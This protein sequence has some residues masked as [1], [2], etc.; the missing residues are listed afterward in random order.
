MVKACMVCHTH[1][2][3]EWYLTASQFL[4]KLVRF[5][6]DLLENFGEEGDPQSGAHAEETAPFMLDGQWIALEDYLR[7]RPAAEE[8]VKRA[9]RSG[10]LQVGPWYILPDEVLVSAE[11]HVRNALMGQRMADRYGGG[12]RVG[13]LPDSFGHP[14]QM[15]QILRGLGF[16]I[17]LFWRGTGHHMS[18]TE[19]IW[20][21]PYE[22][23]E[24]L[25]VHLA[26]GYGNS[27]CLSADMEQ[28]APRLIAM[29]GDL[30]KKSSTDLPLLMNGSDHIV[31]QRDVA[32]VLRA[33]QQLHPEYEIELTT[34][35][36]Y[37]AQL[38]PRLRELARYAGEV[39]YGDRAM[40]LGG[41]LST[42]QALKQQ[43][44]HV[45]RTM[46]R[47]L[48][49]LK[50]CEG[51]MGLGSSFADYGDLLWRRILENHPH[52]S[53]CGCGIDALHAEMQT[54]FAATRELQDT[55]LADAARELF[56]AHRAE[57]PGE[58]LTLLRFEPTQDG[59]PAYVETEVLL[60]GRM[61]SRVNFARSIIDIYDAE[62]P[63]PP[64][65]LRALDSQGREV[66]VTLLEC[67]A[68]DAMHLQDT[69]A[70][71]VYRAYRCRVAMLLPPSPLGLTAVTLRREDSAAPA[72]PRA[73][74]AGERA[75]ENVFYRVSF[76]AER[77]AFAV[78][79]K[80]TGTT[81]AGFARLI[82]RAD[83][84]DEY[85]YSWPT[86]DGEFSL[87]TAGLEV[88]TE[89]IGGFSR[90]LIVSGKLALP[91]SLTADRQRR[92]EERVDC[93]VKLTL[94]LH[95]GIDRIDVSID[96]ENCAEDHRLQVEFPAGVCA[97]TSVASSAFWVSERPVAL[98]VP[99]EWME[100][101][102]PSS[103]THGFV[104]VSD[105]NKG[106]SLACDG[107][108]EYE[109]PRE[110][111]QN[112][113]RVTLLRCVGWLSRP[114]LHTRKGNGGWQIATPG[115]Q[116]PG[117]FSA[118][119]SVRYHAGDWRQAGA[120]GF[121]DRFLHP[122]RLFPCFP[123]HGVRPPRN[124][125]AFLS[126]LPADVRLSACKPAQDERGWVVRVYNL[127]Q[128][129]RAV[130]LPLPA[131]IGGVLRCDLAERE[132]VPVSCAVSDSDPELRF[133]IAPGEVVSLR[134]MPSR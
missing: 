84:G 39:R 126:A 48:E 83:A 127:A 88:R 117:L 93:P 3:R 125:L 64:V 5:V 68:N 44:A 69:T 119:L 74:G 57:R 86:H 10:R 35:E 34:L 55:L 91:R 41:T 103:P 52:D 17:A 106:I 123:E 109:A 105:G 36:D 82:D 4:P 67:E 15:P 7:V 124:P 80:R 73:E 77:A 76:D 49:P 75:I 118:R 6:D 71:E 28:T 19:F 14:E 59:L 114:D 54:R 18:K 132:L 24:V 9:L 128:E 90:R 1:W 104:S 101:P 56:E 72:P 85:T 131:G 16:D 58:G 30:L 108:T 100:Y 134:L 40:L 53:I 129:H 26:H 45:Q 37:L 113:V 115:A 22:G 98:P 122:P 46:E 95:E 20:R 70:P 32:D 61:F 121:A 110:S 31:R 78:I 63:T 8:R 92:A 29:I 96:F 51:L 33:F 112:R 66:P 60:D 79:D 116:C 65:G 107:L 97:Q 87:D 27:A 99:T 23:A 13:Y 62:L 42:R 21:S 50:T 133:D 111:G 38:K 12:M 81:H 25:C 11:S 47:Y 89:R 120:F 94:A 102:L 2:D 130:R 43:N